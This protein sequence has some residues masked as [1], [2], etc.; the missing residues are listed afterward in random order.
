[1]SAG[2]A[3]SA[4]RGV[5]VTLA[6]LAD[7]VRRRSVELLA[8]RPHR[9]GELA[10]VL[11]VSAPVMSRHLRVLRTA[12]LVEEEHP[13]YDARVRVY[14]LRAPPMR[15]LKGW[16]ADAETGWAEQLAAFKDHVERP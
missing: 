8:D 6:A 13:P 11:G 3:A 4:E 12:E 5:D 14:S 9:A 1:M 16:L 7:P 2:A 10:A 15:E